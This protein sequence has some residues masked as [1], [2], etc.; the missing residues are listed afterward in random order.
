MELRPDGPA[1]RCRRC[2]ISV[3]VNSDN[4]AE[5]KAQGTTLCSG[6]RKYHAMTHTEEKL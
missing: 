5:A 4:E 3:W 6:C 2:G 1:Y